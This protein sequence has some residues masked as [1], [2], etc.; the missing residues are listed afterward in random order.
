MNYPT[1]HELICLFLI[2]VAFGPSSTAIAYCVQDP[3]EKSIPDST[4]IQPQEP[5]VHSATS[6]QLV[7][8]GFSPLFNGTDL[9]GWKNPFDFGTAT[10]VDQEIHLIGEKKFFLVTE[11]SYSDFELIVEI[12]LPEGPANSGVMFRC[13][14]EPNRVYGYQ[15]ECDGSPRRWSAGLYDEGRRQWIWPSTQGRSEAEFLKYEADS[16]AHFARP[17]IRDALKRNDWNRYVLRCEGDHLTIALNGVL[18]TD[19]HDAQDQSGFLGIQHHG[20]KGQTYK[21]RNLFIREIE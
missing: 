7:S 21:F 6:E 18:V 13:H 11:K 19:L 12:N 1:V 2:S 14:V 4:D 10:V 17:E 20:E 16:Q 9:T 5:T 8:L 3:I 15:A